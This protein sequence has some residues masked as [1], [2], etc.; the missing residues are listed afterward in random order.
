MLPE[1]VPIIIPS[2]GVT[3]IEAYGNFEYYKK[4]DFLILKGGSPIQPFYALGSDMD[5]INLASYFCEL[6]C[7]LTDEGEEAGQ[8]LRL[9]LNAFYAVSRELYPQEII[10]AAFEMRAAVISGYAP[11]LDACSFCGAESFESVYLDVCPSV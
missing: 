2:R 11:E 3:P 4:G 1:R 10:K 7:E 5:R 6:V 8:M 9:L